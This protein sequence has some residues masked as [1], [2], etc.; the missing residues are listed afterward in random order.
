MTPEAAR[1]L[2]N[3]EK[4]KNIYHNDHDHDVFDDLALPGPW[5]IG[6]LYK[7]NILDYK[8]TRTG[9]LLLTG[10]SLMTF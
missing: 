2:L 10:A 4:M 7:R 8:I 6:H 5:S 9:K 3:E 1:D